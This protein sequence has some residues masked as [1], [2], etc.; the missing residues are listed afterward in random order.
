MCCKKWADN[1]ANIFF[2]DKI[3]KTIEPNFLDHII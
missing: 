3:F 2:N 1:Y